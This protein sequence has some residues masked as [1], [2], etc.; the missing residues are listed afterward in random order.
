MI[1]TKEHQEAMVNNYR[2]Q[3]HNEYE[4]MGFVDGMNAM[5][6]LIDNKLTNNN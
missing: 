3:G 4:C 5:F 2:K 1:I 6:E